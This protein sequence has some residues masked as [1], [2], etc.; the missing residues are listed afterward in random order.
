MMY[1]RILYDFK[2]LIKKSKNIIICSICI[3]YINFKIYLFEFALPIP[4]CP[5]E[6]LSNVQ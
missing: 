5:T 4:D 6:A 2:L 3:I 1:F